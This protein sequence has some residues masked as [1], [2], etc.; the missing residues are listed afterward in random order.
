MTDIL[1]MKLITVDTALKNAFY[2][3]AATVDD[4]TVHA[5]DAATGKSLWTHVAGSRVDSA[6][7]F[8]SGTIIFGSKTLPRAG[9]LKLDAD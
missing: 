3:F 2:Q 6:P 9:Q 7:T 5:L 8:Y 4:H 1:D